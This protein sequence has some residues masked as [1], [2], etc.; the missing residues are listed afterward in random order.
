MAKSKAD[1]PKAMT[2]SEILAGISEST[3]LAKK[4]VGAV[5]EAM[6]AQIAKAVSKKG[7]GSYAI[8]GLCK[9]VVVN[10]PAQPAKKGVKNPFTGELMD[11]PAKPAKR[12]VKVRP[13][14]QLKDMI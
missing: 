3:G 6:N 2:K 11:V 8:P 1:A 7:A 10:K 12:V 9:I 5:L 13:L 4:D 14:K